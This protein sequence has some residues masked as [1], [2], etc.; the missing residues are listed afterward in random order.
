MRLFEENGLPADFEALAA[1]HVLADHHIV[2]ADHVSTGFGKT[3][4]V[5]FIRAAGKAP[6][7]GAD[8]PGN[9][10]I[11]GLV[12]MGAIQRGRLFLSPF[13][14]K[15]TLFHHPIIAVL[16]AESYGKMRAMARKRKPKKF[17]KVG[18]VKALARERV[19]PPPA[20]KII[21]ERKKKAEKHKPT[22]G[23]M[24]EEN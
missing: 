19:G 11:A 17:N 8:Q 6:L 10:I 15:I 7:L 20:E 21:V 12:A 22:L 14:E 16:E 24:L 13:V 2:L 9:F 5:P 3:G 23:K 4:A 1:A 18:A